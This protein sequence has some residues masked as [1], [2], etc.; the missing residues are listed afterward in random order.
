MPAELGTDEKRRHP[1]SPLNSFLRFP[2]LVATPDVVAITING[3]R[4]QT[5]PGGAR[6][7]YR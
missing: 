6:E 4:Q 5:N 2:P 3:V 7:V 1:R